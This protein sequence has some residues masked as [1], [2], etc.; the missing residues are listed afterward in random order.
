MITTREPIL[1]SLKIFCINNY[2]SISDQMA[3]ATLFLSLTDK[4]NSWEMLLLGTVFPWSR[5]C[6]GRWMSILGVRKLNF[7][8]NKYEIM[9]F[10]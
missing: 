5:N 9:H 8:T 4:L 1:L 6:S 10:R 7:Y 3:Q 2:F